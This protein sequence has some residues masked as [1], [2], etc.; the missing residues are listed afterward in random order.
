MVKNYYQ[1]EIETMPVEEIR[2]L[3]NEKFVKQVKY[4]YENVA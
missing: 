2:K 1:P 4:V 3:Q